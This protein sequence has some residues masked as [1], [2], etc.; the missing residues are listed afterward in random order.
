MRVLLGASLR[1]NEQFYRLTLENAG[2]VVSLD[3]QSQTS[4]I[5]TVV[6]LMTSD[7]FDSQLRELRKRSVRV[8]PVLI[9]GSTSFIDSVDLALASAP[10]LPIDATGDELLRTIGFVS[11]G[12]GWLLKELLGID[13]NAKQIAGNDICEWVRSRHGIIG[14]IRFAESESR[15]PSTSLL[16]RLI[17]Q[18]YTLLDDLPRQQFSVQDVWN[19]TLLIAVPMKQTE[20]QQDTDLDRSLDQVSRDLSGARKIVLW[21]DKGIR[22]YF[23]PLTL[24]H[25]LT[26]LPGVDP[27]R[28]T[29][30]RLATDLKERDALEVIFKSRLSQEDIDQL[31]QVLGRPS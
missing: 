1:S 25:H 30:A 21:L 19:V 5:D 29:L 26:E 2:Y 13:E 18:A 6:A 4:D 3:G 22:D 7:E 23:G 20:R 14:I 28:S 27:L 8:L 10:N 15:K 24:G 16:R 12:D 11:R 17:E 9:G 31:M